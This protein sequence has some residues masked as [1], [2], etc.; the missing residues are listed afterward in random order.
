M[1]STKR[2]VAIASA[3]V[4]LGVVVGGLA[5]ASAAPTVSASGTSTASSVAGACGGLGL[6]LGGAVRDAGGRLVDIV[7]NKTGMSVESVQ[8]ARQTGTSFADMT[9]G[10][11]ATKSDVVA[12]AVSVR[13][14]VLAAKVAGGTI[15]QAQAD[16]AAAAMKTRL[17]QRWDSTAACGGGGCGGTGA[18]C[19][20]GRGMGGGC[21]GA[22]AGTGPAA[23]Q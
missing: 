19:G 18:G 14:K 5:S 4:V 12:E 7:A 23:T 2:A 15:T 3:A 8:A 10:S 1:I 11:G 21:G 22:C 16:A 6:R 13:M 17:K 9:K 20:G